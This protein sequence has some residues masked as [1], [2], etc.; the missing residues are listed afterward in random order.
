M[1]GS[2]VVVMCLSV[3]YDMVKYDDIAVNHILIGWGATFRC[4]QIC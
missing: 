3:G 2:A 1:H 4:C